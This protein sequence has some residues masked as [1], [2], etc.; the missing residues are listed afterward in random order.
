MTLSVGVLIL[1][2]VVVASGIA[3]GLAL[4]WLIEHRE[5]GR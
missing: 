2:L 4:A 5:D 3:G 1:V